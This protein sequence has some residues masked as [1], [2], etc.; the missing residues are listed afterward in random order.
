[1]DANSV[2]FFYS[3]VERCVAQCNRIRGPMCVNTEKFTVLF[4]REEQQTFECIFFILLV[5]QLAKHYSKETLLCNN[6]F[7]QATTRD[8]NCLFIQPR[9]IFSRSKIE[10]NNI[11]PIKFHYQLSHFVKHTI[12]V[13]NEYVP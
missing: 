13:I 2:D 7:P 3:P 12:N 8:Q 10:E 6:T 5:S 9:L 1:M 4:L 11:L